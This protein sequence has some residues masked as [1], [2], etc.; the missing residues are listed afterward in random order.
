MFEHSSVST[1]I[2]KQKKKNKNKK[3]LGKQLYLALL[4]LHA[5]LISDTS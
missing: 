5:I 4:S 1:K 3:R 2:S